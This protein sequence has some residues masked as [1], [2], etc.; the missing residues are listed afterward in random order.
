VAEALAA[1]SCVPCRGGVPTLTREQIAPLLEQLEG[2]TVE[3][4]KKLTKSYRFGNFREALAFV[5]TAGEIA[6]AEGHHPDLHLAWGH[7][8]VELWTHK[9]GGLHEN[10]FV[11]AAKLDQ[12]RAGLP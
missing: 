8:G 5:N 10:D 12:A 2:W 4:D 11:M 3:D 6:E 9:I 1:R 7:V